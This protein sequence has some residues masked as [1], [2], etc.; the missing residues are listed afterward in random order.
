MFTITEGGTNSIIRA[1]CN[2]S[3][4]PNIATVFSRSI[5][6]VTKAENS[7]RPAASRRAVVA[8][9]ASRD[10]SLRAAAARARRVGGRRSCGD[11]FVIGSIEYE[12]AN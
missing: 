8:A 4:P 10:S 9:H 12:R 1:F 3:A 2:S 11:S 7:S 5:T 6:E